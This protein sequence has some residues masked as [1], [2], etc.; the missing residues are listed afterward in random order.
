MA[1]LSSG[2]V[3]ARQVLRGARRTLPERKSLGYV[4]F[5]LFAQRM[6]VVHARSLR[7][8]R[9]TDRRPH[10]RRRSGWP[11]PWRGSPLRLAS[12]AASVAR[13]HLAGE[14]AR[15]L[16]LGWRV[17]PG[18]A[19][20]VLRLAGPRGRAAVAWGAGDHGAAIRILAASPRRLAD[21]ALAVARPDIAAVALP[22]VPAADPALPALRARL[23]WQ[24]GRLTDAIAELDSARG[25]RARRLQQAYRAELRVRTGEL[26]GRGASEAKGPRP[27]PLHAAN[28]QRILHLV[29][30]ALPNVTAGYTVRTRQ[31]A[32][33]QQAAGLDPQVLTRLGFPV[34]Q[35]HRD[36]RGTVTVEGIPY[37][38]L[39]PYHLPA[40]PDAAFEAGLAQASRLAGR[41][42]PAVLHAA[43]N[44]LNGQL[45]LALRERCGLPVVYEV[46]GFLEESWRSRAGGDV[47]ASESYLLSREL[48]T[49]CMQQAE[50]VVT[51]GEVMREEIMSR[52]VPGEKIIVVPNA[53]SAEF[54]TPLPDG[55]PLRARLG[56]GPGEFVP[57]LSSSLYPHEGVR[58][59]LEAAALLRDQGLPIRPL[60]VGDG[61]ERA[62]LEHLARRLGLAGQAIFTGRVPPS[63]VRRY[64]AVLDLFVIPRTSDRVCQLVTPLKPVEAMASGL[65]VVA[66]EVGGLRE[67][68]EHQSTG[69]LTVP[70]DPVALAGC[71]ASLLGQPALRR[72]IG[73]RARDW[74]GRERT[75]SRNAERYRAAYEALG[76]P[77]PIPR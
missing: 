5:A 77:V 63:E 73:A 25:R 56:I 61:P 6:P 16:W 31:I 41:L 43:T 55:G 26:A 65:C 42:R 68:V 66:S 28:P 27:R 1:F 29:T 20:P 69:V 4:A 50:L 8:R 24:Q 67:I 48:E 40:R 14:P 21:F 17:L 44:H 13:R 54:L 22:R 37:H 9:V 12:L 64:H 71:M 60:I 30:D 76:S 72:E 70:E 33:A 11:A 7:S 47:S 53:V 39:L 49:W 3:A 19:R 46:R 58:Y 52:G 59:F 18:P 57:G 74:A 32:V 2:L 35:G 23:A 34:A 45:A 10:P 75:W 15:A 36:A 51:L 38:R 62:S